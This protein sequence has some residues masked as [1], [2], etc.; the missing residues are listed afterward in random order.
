VISILVVHPNLAKII[1]Y[2]IY[3]ILFPLWRQDIMCNLTCRLAHGTEHIVGPICECI[4]EP[5]GGIKLPIKTGINGYSM[6]LYR[7]EPGGS[8]IKSARTN[9]SE[10]NYLYAICT[11]I[12]MQQE[13][14]HYYL[15]CSLRVRS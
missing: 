6:L 10:L 14:Q 13:R 2:S 8:I 1:L 15:Q 5:N 7:R 4:K 3:S 9:N 12:R 11:L